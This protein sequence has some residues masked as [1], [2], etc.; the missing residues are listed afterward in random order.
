MSVFGKSNT[1]NNVPATKLTE[2]GSEEMILRDNPQNSPPGDLGFWNDVT[3][4]ADG[5]LDGPKGIQVTT[6]YEVT[7]V[8]ESRANHHMSI[9]SNR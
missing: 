8:E 2:N 3:T 6:T 4:S 7:Q 1:Q 5:G 9:S